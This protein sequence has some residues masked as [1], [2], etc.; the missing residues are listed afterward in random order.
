MA[1]IKDEK[2]A[3]QEVKP[4]RSLVPIRKWIESWHFCSG[5][6]PPGLSRRGLSIVSDGQDIE[7]EIMKK[8]GVGLIALEDR[9]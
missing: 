4:P 7:Y 3:E 2:K 1:D 8:D 6:V 5:I 9:A